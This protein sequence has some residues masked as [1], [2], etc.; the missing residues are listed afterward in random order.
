VQW[1]LYT[2]NPEK[3]TNIFPEPEIY[4]EGVII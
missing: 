2:P 4:L 3:T 1:I